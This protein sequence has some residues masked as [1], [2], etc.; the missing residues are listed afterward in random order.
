MAGRIA[1]VLLPPASRSLKRNCCRRQPGST[2][3]QNAA[4]LGKL[5]HTL[6]GC[7]SPSP[8]VRRF[9]G[10]Q[11]YP[12][13]SELKART[14]LSFWH[15]SFVKSICIL[16]AAEQ[17]ARHL[18]ERIAHGELSGFMPG[19]AVLAR[20]LGIGRTTADA[21]LDILE[22]EGLLAPAGE[23]KRR[24]ILAADTPDEPKPMRVCLILYEPSDAANQYV[25]EIRQLL[26]ASGFSLELS[27]KTLIE[28]DHNPGKV[29]KMVRNHPADAWVICSGSRP[30]LEWFAESSIPAF[31]LFGRMHGIAIPGIKPDKQIA[32]NEALKTLIGLGHRKIVLL[33]RE[34]RRKPTMGDIEVA[35]LNRLEEYGI[36]TG[37]YNIPDWAETASGLR[38]CIDMLSS[39]TPPTAIFV[40]DSVLFLA[41]QNILRNSGSGWSKKVVL[42][43]TDY[44]PHMDWCDPPVPHFSWNHRSTARRILRWLKNLQ[45]DKPDH[46]QTFAST[47]FVEGGI[48]AYDPNR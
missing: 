41:V 40:G 44:H 34:E 23:R 2:G 31:A 18:K 13:R 36:K 22:A 19:G 21:A 9:T 8:S 27:P 28:L 47:R 25:P 10:I 16:S 33:V 17:V 7:D 11:R 30:I 48:R 5:C 39:L 15:N 24:R 42:I 46:K 26:L 12:A 6:G 37:P 45:R 29:G 32:M 14:C 4:I 43:S 38:R 20:G 1:S 3:C 35:F